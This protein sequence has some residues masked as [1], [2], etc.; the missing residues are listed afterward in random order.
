MSDNFQIAELHLQWT[1]WDFGRTPGRYGEATSSEA[2][3]ELLY[4]RARQTLAFNLKRRRTRS[5][6]ARANHVIAA[7]AVRRA[8]SHL[9]DACAISRARGEH[10]AKRSVPRP[11]F[12]LSGDELYLVTTETSEGI[13]VADLNR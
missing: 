2:I 1:V 12:N 8:E 4:H 6:N 11:S 5:Q 13:T 7:E 10:L 3:A 9:R